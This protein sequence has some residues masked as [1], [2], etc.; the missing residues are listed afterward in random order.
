MLSEKRKNIVPVL[1]DCKQPQT[2]S[3]RIS[4][5]DV[6]YQD[7]AQKDQVDIFL[8]NCN[9]YL[10]KDGFALLCVK[11]RSVDV[12]KKPAE[13]FNKVRAELEDKITI[14]D[15]R[16]LE[17]FEKDHAIFVCKKK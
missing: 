16:K 14:V 7:I 2:Y 11:A 5:A 8:K 4:M 15:Y 10:K 6:V 12:T 13:I 3:D 9:M 1:A 17:P